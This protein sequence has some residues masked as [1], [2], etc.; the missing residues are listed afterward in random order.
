MNA[1]VCNHHKGQACPIC[2]MFE[3]H[4]LKK[5]MNW[6]KLELPKIG[7]V[8]FLNGRQVAEYSRSG[9]YLEKYWDVHIM[10][11]HYINKYSTTMTW[12]EVKLA[13][14]EQIYL[15]LKRREAR[16]TVIKRKVV[17]KVIRR[18]YSK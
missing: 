6:V 1:I 8:A 2:D 15:R 4:D 11:V 17:R 5:K 13:I 3:F 16:K 14:E 7:S 18:V 12:A 10:G 9:F